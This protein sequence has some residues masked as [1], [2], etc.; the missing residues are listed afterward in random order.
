MSHVLP[1]VLLFVCIPDP[2]QLV[3]M[4]ALQF[5]DPKVNRVAKLSINTVFYLFIYLLLL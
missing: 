4:P 3:G 5:Q 1:A 2:A